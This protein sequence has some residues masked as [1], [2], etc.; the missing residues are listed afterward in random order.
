MADPMPLEV[1]QYL[2]HLAV[3]CS[4]LSR[5]TSDPF[6]SGELETIS[7]ELVEWAQ[8]I[9]ALLK[10]PNAAADEADPNAVD[11]VAIDRDDIT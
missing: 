8:A 7:V 10:L 1:A 5:D 3:R 9:E 2:R 4:R 11:I 6:V